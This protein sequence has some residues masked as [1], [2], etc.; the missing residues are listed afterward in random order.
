MRRCGVPD[1][2][3][4]VYLQSYP[5]ELTCGTMCDGDEEESHHHRSDAGGW[6][7]ISTTND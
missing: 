1:L 3:D 7:G 4:Q 5:I 6:T 2:A